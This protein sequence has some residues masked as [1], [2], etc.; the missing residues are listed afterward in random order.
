MLD[1]TD[2]S[3]APWYRIQADDKRRARLNCI[4][5]LLSVIPY[6]DVPA[7]IIEMPEREVVAE[8][9]SLDIDP[10]NYIPEEY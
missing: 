4:T 9:D 5:H 6:E 7:K 10:A 8:P 3:H 1:A 2:T